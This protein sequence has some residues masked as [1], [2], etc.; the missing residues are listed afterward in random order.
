[1]SVRLGRLEGN[2]SSNGCLVD[3][4]DRLPLPTHDTHNTVTA[5]QVDRQGRRLS[6]ELGQP[7]LSRQSRASPQTC[8]GAWPN[9]PNCQ[10]SLLKF[11]RV[12]VPRA[13]DPSGRL[14]QVSTVP[15]S[16]EASAVVNTIPGKY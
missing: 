1:M 11:D 5:F 4:G 13:Q 16:K 2:V 8:S 10:M 6:L 7:G 9:L 15:I 3:S 14:K 12:G